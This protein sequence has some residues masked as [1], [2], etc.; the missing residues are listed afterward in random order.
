MAAITEEDSAVSLAGERGS[1]QAA[2]AVGVCGCF[3]MAEAGRVGGFQQL[4]PPCKREQAAESDGKEGHWKMA[5]LAPE[6]CV[7]GM[8]EP[9][10]EGDRAKED[11]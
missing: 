7:G 6:P 10:Q 4:G 8:G 2:E 9:G 5:Q 1:P 11:I 3:A